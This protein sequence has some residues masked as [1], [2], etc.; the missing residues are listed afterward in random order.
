MFWKTLAMFSASGFGRCLR[1][2]TKIGGIARDDGIAAL[3]TFAAYDTYKTTL[4][5]QDV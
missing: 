2:L 4:E 3:L 5:F 1:P